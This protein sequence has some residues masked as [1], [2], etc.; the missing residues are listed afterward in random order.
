MEA[1]QAFEKIVKPLITTPGKKIG[2]L[3]HSGKQPEYVR[4]R[5][6]LCYGSIR[7]L[8]MTPVAVSEM[9]GISQS[10]V[11]RAAY[12]GKAIAADNNIKL[13]TTPKA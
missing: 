5:S 7:E 3:L 1:G 6:L 4:A 8:G 11:T 10:A 12:R 9:I 2:D 13:V